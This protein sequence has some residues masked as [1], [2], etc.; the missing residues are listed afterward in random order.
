MLFRSAGGQAGP[1]KIQGIGANFIPQNFDKNVIDEIIP[2]KNEDAI[3]TARNL[4]KKE[5][6]LSGFSGGAN[7]WAAIELSKR[8]ENKGKLIVAIL[9]DC[10]ERYLSSELYSG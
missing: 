10:G 1:H 9:P 8:P 2:V 7:I 3:E 4:S 5:G 6:I